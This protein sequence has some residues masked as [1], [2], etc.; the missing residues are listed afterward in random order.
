MYAVFILFLKLCHILEVYRKLCYIIFDVINATTLNS[1]LKS[2]RVL[3]FQCAD[4]SSTS[5]GLV[6]I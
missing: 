5:S 3:T 2:H 4:I 1:I 6:I